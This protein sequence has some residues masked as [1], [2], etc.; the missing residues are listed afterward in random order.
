MRRSLSA[1]LSSAPRPPR[2]A[3]GALDKGTRRAMQHDDELDFGEDDLVPPALAHP[4]QGTDTRSAGHAAQ[5]GMEGSAGPTQGHSTHTGP[6]AA[7]AGAAPLP[8]SSSL[9][10]P[11]PASTAAATAPAKTSTAAKAAH[12][13]T[14]DANGNKLPAGWVSRLSKSTGNIYYRN[15]LL[16]TSEW[17]IPTEPARGKQATPPSPAPAPPAAESAQV[18]APEVAAAA[19]ETHASAST[20]S[21]PQEQA[22]AAD[23]A[24]KQR[25]FVHPDRL[26]L[27]GVVPAPAPP[28]ALRLS[29]SLCNPCT[30]RA[31]IRVLSP[32]AAAAP[33]GPSTPAGNAQYPPRRS[34][35]QGKLS[36][37]LS[38]RCRARRET[39]LCDIS[40][41]RSSRAAAWRICP[42]PRGSEGRPA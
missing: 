23:S 7:P 39:G 5:A 28:G 22:A 13:E 33:T 6:A 15:T 30:P 35:A 21:L 8:S 3:E 25:T 2:A 27:A 32:V 42:A 18:Q 20:E 4:H 17:D 41:V 9:A 29:L 11:A 31:D 37:S 10:Q 12:D 40:R 16:N 38:R 1:L 26:K 19:A 34:V 14:L 24:A 36:F